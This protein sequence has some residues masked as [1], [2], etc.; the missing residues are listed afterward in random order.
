MDKIKQWMY[1][2]IIALISLVTLIFLPMV[3]STADLGWNLPN[4]TVG[5]VIWIVVK[6]IVAGI[7]VLIFHCFMLQAKIN[8]KDDPKYKEANKLLEQC[9]HRK[10]RIPR[11]PLVWNR[12]QYGKKGVSIFVI[13]A[14]ST[15]ALTQA[16]LTFDYMS[17]LTYLFTIVM[18]LIF[19]ILQM[20]SAEE[21]WTTE[22][23]EHAHYIY[24]QIMEEKKYG[25]QT[26]E[27]DSIAQSG[28]TSKTEPDRYC[29]SL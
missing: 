15:V 11:S 28:R 14:L 20:K 17:M 8:I 25:N 27:R 29:P 12:Q 22:Y 10:E 4:T 5:W 9:Q 21:Y 13:T 2:L 19:G 16:I 26:T 24:K 3:G 6:L 23:W 1:Y 7:G 18:N